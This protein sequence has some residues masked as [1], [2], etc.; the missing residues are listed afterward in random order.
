MAALGGAIADRLAWVFLAGHQ[1]TIRRC[2]PTLPAEQGWCAFVNSEDRTGAVPGTSLTGGPGNWRLSGA[3]SWVAAADHIDRL[4]V[5]ARRN[6]VP[7]IV[8]RRDQPGVHI[9]DVTP[10]GY[11]SELAQGRVRFDDAAVRDE[12]LIGDEQSFAAFGFAETAYIRVAL[13]AFML[14]HAL[15][16]GAPT[17]L[18][19]GAVSGLFSSAAILY[20]QP[21]YRATALG[22]LGVDTNTRWLASEFEEFIQLRDDALHR[23][24]IKDRGL[25]DGPSK[26]IA[27]R[28]EAALRASS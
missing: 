15:R 7:C 14:S 10:K 27:A 23:V 1:G 26:G 24:W 11:L 22:F 12:H 20:M 4:I 13:N 2:F 3:K 25:V 19:G 9:Y 18:I 17:W 8:V 6:E 5:S 16:L 28:A 21:P